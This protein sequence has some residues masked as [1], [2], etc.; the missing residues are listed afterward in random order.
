MGTMYAHSIDA[1][2]AKE[3][4]FNLQTISQAGRRGFDP[5]LPLQLFNNLTSIAQHPSPL[6]SIYIIL[7]LSIAFSNS[8]TAS[9]LRPNDACVYT[10]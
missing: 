1:V 10:F 3:F 9:R 2:D 7:M 8:F 6:K 4:I 5:R